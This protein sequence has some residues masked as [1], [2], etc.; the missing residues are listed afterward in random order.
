MAQRH[1][2]SLKRREIRDPV[3]GRRIVA[4]TAGPAN[5]WPL[6]A[7]DTPLTPAGDRL[8][9]LS[10][11]AGGLNLFRLEMPAGAIDQVTETDR[12]IPEGITPAAN[13]RQAIALLRG[14]EG[15]VVAI[16]LETGEW[17]TLAVFMDARLEGCHRSASGEYVVTVVT[18]DQEAVITAVHTEGMRTVPIHEAPRAV[19]GAR[20]SPDSRNSVLYITDDPPEIRCVEFDGTGDRLLGSGVQGFRGSGVRGLTVDHPITQNHDPL[21]SPP[22]IWRGLGEEILF[23]A[24]PGPGPIM[25]IPRQEGSP[26]E[27]SSLPSLWVRSDGSGEQFVAL[28]A[29]GDEAVDPPSFRIVQI[30]AHSGIV[31]PLISECSDWACPCFSPDGR[32]V[33]YTGRDERGFTQLFQAFLQEE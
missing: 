29:S 15:E 18:Q 3:T 33:V 6:T 4:L 17:E 14:E 31:K 23:I 13:G 19:H 16:D 24:G 10:D 8:L 5:H 22:P 11:A 7:P 2:A 32:S 25:A 9:F 21:N 26:R 27:V 28:V 1:H 20:F 30:T 12:L